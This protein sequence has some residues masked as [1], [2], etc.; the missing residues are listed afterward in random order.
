M[1]LIFLK[2]EDFIGEALVRLH[3]RRLEHVLKVHRANVGDELRVGLS[4]GKTGLGRVERIDSNALEMTVRFFAE[5]L[6]P[7]PL[8]LILALPRPKVLNRTIAAAVSMGI[9]EIDLI[10]AWR[11][12]KAYWSS[13]RLSEENLTAQAVLGLEQ[14]GDTIL[15]TIRLHR[16]FAPFARVELAE[17]VRGRLALVADP[18][19]EAACPRAVAGPVVLAIGPEGGFIERELATF[20]DAGFAAIT[21]GRRILRVET[22]LAYLIGRVSP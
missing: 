12:E 18:G 8:R 7:L 5:P 14:A 22:A 17:M 3:G 19:G 6:D 4:G 20:R 2:F 16:L 13:P 10:N 21:L 11:V 15:P 9:R 1:N